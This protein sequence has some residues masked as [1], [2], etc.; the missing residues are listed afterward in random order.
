[1]ANVLSEEIGSELEKAGLFFRVFW[2]CKES[3][4][5]ERK[6]QTLDENGI[7]KYDAVGKR[8]RDVIGIRINLY[9][10]DDLELATAYVQEKYAHLF[11]E[12]TIDLNTTTEFKPTRTNLVFHIPDKYQDEFR[13]VVTDNRI[14]A[15][16]ELQLRTI[17][18]EGWHEVEHDMRYKCQ[19]DWVPYPEMS[20][21]FNGFLAALETYELS[22]V[23]F[24]EKIAY[25]HYKNENMSAFI[26]NK[27]RIRFTETLLPAELLQA[28]HAEA[29]FTRDLFKIERHRVIRRLLKHRLPFPL[30][31]ANVIFFINFAFIHNE[32]VS[33]I[34]PTLLK[35]ALRELTLAA[36]TNKQSPEPKIVKQ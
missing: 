20:R 23:H 4:S 19:D 27:L 22:M 3:R 30:T 28:L 33:R 17:H 24:F 31:L 32:E 11:A 21:M 13:R 1:M 25:E 29:S 18:S 6:L 2:R 36:K 8:L 5:L 34:T 14:D 7:K 10:V 35:D 15:T 16:F 9:F 26:L 12:E